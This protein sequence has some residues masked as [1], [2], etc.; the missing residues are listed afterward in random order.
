M[1]F[2]VVSI[3]LALASIAALLVMF[4]GK[5]DN[6]SGTFLAA[7]NKE[8]EEAFIQYIAKYGKTYASKQEVTKR[9]SN[10][11]KWY[12][13]VQEHNQSEDKT[14]EMELN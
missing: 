6:T 10:F 3:L 4:T 11:A 12:L 9:Y 5:L 7:E 13:L 1:K 8:I 2:K 14:Y